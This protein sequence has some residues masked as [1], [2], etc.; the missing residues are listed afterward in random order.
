MYILG[1]TGGFDRVYEARYG[2]P[3]DFAHDAAAVLVRDG[4]I[5]A[6]TEEERLNRIKHTNK[7]PLQAIRFCLDSAG[8][9]IE[10][11]DHFA[12]YA[13][14]GFMNGWFHRQHLENPRLGPF[15]D[16]RSRMQN[17]FADNF[18]YRPPA[19]RFH[20]VSHHMSHAVSSFALCGFDDCL[21]LSIDGVG[22]SVSTMVLSGFGKELRVLSSKPQ[23]YSLGIY[24]LKVIGFLGY[25]IYDE[26]K[27]M[28]LAPY[29][30]PARFRDLF[31]QFYALLPDGEYVIYNERVMQLYE[32]LNPRQRDETFS[33]LHKDIAAALQESL[34]SIVFH[35]LRHYRALT[36]HE[37]LAIS[38]GVGQNTSMIGKLW[39]SGL[40]KDI[41]VQPAADD[42]GCAIGCALA[43][44]HQINPNL[45]TYRLEQV[46][47]G[48][49]IGSDEEIA[50]CLAG[51]S[52][53]VEFR[54]M[55]DPAGETARLLADGAVAGLVQG[56]AEYGP[57]ALGNRSI[58]ADPRPAANKDIVNGMIKKR[59][60]YR[61]FAP[62]IL[63][64]R[65]S[66][67]FEI[68]PSQARF[69][70]MSSI[71][72]VQ[73][74]WR[75]TLGAITHVDGSA[76]LQT[77]SRA[78]NARYYA[79]IEAFGKLT[80]IP[81]LLNT[82][83][84]NNVEPIVN[85]VDEAVT[86]F[87]T[88]GLNILVVGD[89]LIDKKVLTAEALSDFRLWLSPCSAASAIHAF[90]DESRQETR[91][92]LQ[93]NYDATLRRDI[94]AAAF[95]LIQAA[96]QQRRIGELLAAHV[97]GQSG[98]AGLFDE[99]LALWEQRWVMIRP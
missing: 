63:E 40:F 74:A 25:R 19:E 77:V 45:P 97:S 1:L 39:D 99:L 17:L 61:P 67:F 15:I 34:E 8:I 50:R 85:T 24:Y 9:P 21:L 59:E 32:V 42:S 5:I 86:C 60:G 31:S 7:A 78:S 26:Y 79:L 44:A 13:T 11:I 18:G 94:S 90:V 2:F 88:S 4:E 22:E 14:E 93:R 35:I 80:G 91:Y 23:Q 72:K 16:I 83:F 56:R 71:L 27:V 51:W 12:F 87:L 29:G 76:R 43:V 6:A 33:Q 75:D 95:A 58:V 96:D 48:S 69:P 46:Y 55:A 52:A 57:R 10:A 66:E 41:F 92:Q 68:P 49:D 28:G 62:S 98:A 53:L 64:E 81:I 82:S 65:A 89:Y 84:N 73:P 36:G 3:I 38:G 20:F 54:K 30:D 70:F 37:N 47:W